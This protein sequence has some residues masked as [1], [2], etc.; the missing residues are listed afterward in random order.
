MIPLFSDI[1]LLV[2]VLNV[3]YINTTN[4][5]RQDIVSS[6]NPGRPEGTSGLAGALVQISQSPFTVADKF[7]RATGPVGE[8][9]RQVINMLGPENR[10]KWAEIAE[11]NT[12]V[13]TSLNALGVDVSARLIRQGYVVAMCNLYVIFGGEFPLLPDEVAAERF[14][15]LIS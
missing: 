4:V 2:R 10:D 13:P 11:E 1:A 7:A 14:R 3:M 15:S 8:R 5:R 12:N 6:Y 9:A